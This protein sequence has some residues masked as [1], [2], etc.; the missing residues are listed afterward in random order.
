MPIEVR[1]MIV[2][3]SV[4]PT[5]S[6][7]DDDRRDRRRVEALKREVLEEVRRQMLAIRND[8]KER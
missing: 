1:Q 3:S 8:A 7:T 2:R 5:S 6:A 4:T